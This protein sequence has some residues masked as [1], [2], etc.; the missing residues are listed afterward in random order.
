MSGLGIPEQLK[1]NFGTFS[2]TIVS[3]RHLA[4]LS[5]KK[6]AYSYKNNKPHEQAGCCGVKHSVADVALNAPSPCR[7]SD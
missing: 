1:K 3:L 5:I 7:C 2:Q 4:P 6:V